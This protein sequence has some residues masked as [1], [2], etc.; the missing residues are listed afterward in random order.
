MA[1]LI[2]MLTSWS[3]LLPEKFFLKIVELYLKPRLHR[4]ISDSW[5]PK[6]I[7]DPT[8]LIENWLLPW[9]ELLG[10]HEMHSFFVQVKLKLTNVLTHWKTDSPLAKALVSPWRA[11]LEEKSFENLIMRSIVPKLAFGLKQMEINPQD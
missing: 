4:E 9:R 1:E 7:E 6:N 5:D 10:D 3:H 2:S 8:N 11:V